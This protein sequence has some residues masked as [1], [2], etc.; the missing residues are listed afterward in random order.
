MPIFAHDGLTSRC[1]AAT[2]S[3]PFAVV[4]LVVGGVANVA[5]MSIGQTVVQLLASAADRGR[6]IRLYGVSSSGLRAG[7]GCTATS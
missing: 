2:A 4:L 7:S 6:V 1:F 5:S 3:Y